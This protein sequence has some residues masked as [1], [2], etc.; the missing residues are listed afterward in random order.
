[1]SKADSV[2][3]LFQYQATPAM[4]PYGHCA[5]WLRR[6]NRLQSGRSGNGL[7]GRRL[8]LVADDPTEKSSRLK[9]MSAI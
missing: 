1:V 5:F 3:S 7:S 2:G 6:K 9:S 8:N 4:S